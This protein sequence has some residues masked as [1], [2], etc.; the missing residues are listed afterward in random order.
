V[1]SPSETPPDPVRRQLRQRLESWRSAGVEFL[2]TAGAPPEGFGA[3]AEEDEAAGGAA[4]GDQRV[5]ELNV[6]AERVSKC[7]RCAELC[8]TRTQTVFGVGPLDP[9]LCF[10]GEAPGADEDRQGEPFVGAAGQLLNRIISAMGMRREEVFI[11]NILRCR[12]PGNRQPKPDEARNCREYLDG[13]LDLV[14]PKFICALGATAAQ[15]LLATSKSLGK[16]RGEFH[17]Y[18]GIPVLCTYHPAS[19]LPSRSPQNKP[20]VWDDMKMLLAKLGRPIPS[21]KKTS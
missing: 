21:G 9:D 3:V 2:P 18:R 1:S 4:G 13:T 6:L 16:L 10:I 12:P 14:R 15:S 19:L 5:V 17:A 11:C 7:T 8:S 20:L